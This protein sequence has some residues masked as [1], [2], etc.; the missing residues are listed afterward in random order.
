MCDP[1]PNKS[2]NEFHALVVVRH[3]FEAMTLDQLITLD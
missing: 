1:A 2:W 3:R